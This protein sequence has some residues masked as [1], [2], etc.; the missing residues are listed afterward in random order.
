M[1]L[2]LASQLLIL[3]YVSS[4]ERTAPFAVCSAKLEVYAISAQS[5][6][7]AGIEWGLG[8][9]CLGPLSTRGAD[10]LIRDQTGI[11]DGGRCLH[12]AVRSL[13]SGIDYSSY[14][15]SK[16]FFVI[17]MGAMFRAREA[18]GAEEQETC[19]TRRKAFQDALRE[20]GISE[21]LSAAG[22]ACSERSFRSWCRGG[23]L[24]CYCLCPHHEHTTS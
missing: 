3:N 13:S 20:C 19:V 11:Y 22:E 6:N 15:K 16:R 18:K 4:Q 7:E 12:I 21:S 8:P 1:T 14:E 23:L 10:P 9:D 24:Y 5:M 2:D 17:L